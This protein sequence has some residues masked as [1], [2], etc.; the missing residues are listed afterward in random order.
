M[1]STRTEPLSEPLPEPFPDRVLGYIVDFA[2][3]AAALSGLALVLVVGGNVL[4]RYVFNT[5]SVAMQELEW[6]LV[7]P[8]A[9]LGMAYGMR[10]GGHVRVDFLY[11]RLSDRARAMI[12]LFSAVLMVI[13][14]AAII[15]FA[16]PYVS[17]SIM[18]G[19]GSPD[20]GGLP[21]RFLLKAFIPVGFGLLFVQAIAQALINFR[22]VAGAG[23]AADEPDDAGYAT[24]KTAT[25]VPG[26]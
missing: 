25:E 10:H 13:L 4:L 20:P 1:N 8:I 7:S 22:Q 2:G 16:I 3:W 15:W 24:H 26:E 9:L 11:D 23:Q 5:G 21:Y 6:H 12:D 14:G 19:E 18:M 17:Q